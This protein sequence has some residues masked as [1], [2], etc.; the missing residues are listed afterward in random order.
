VD[1]VEPLGRPEE[2][3]Q[4]LDRNL[5]GFIT[6][7]LVETCRKK[8]PQDMV[9]SY[10]VTL[11]AGV[12]LAA[13]AAEIAAFLAAESFVIERVRKKKRRELDLRPLVRQLV[14]DGA[15]LEIVLLHPHSAAG[16]NPREVLTRILGLDDEQA[17]LA[18]IVK[19]AVEEFTANS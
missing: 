17:L 18:G 10:R 19:T 9:A 13:A 1:L 7:T 8:T 2:T 15:A 3:A 5:P 14:L 16:T 11:P 12:D 4:L 6:V